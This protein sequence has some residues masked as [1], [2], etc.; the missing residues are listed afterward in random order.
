MEKKNMLEN[1]L[2]EKCTAMMDK[3]ITNIKMYEMTFQ[4]VIEEIYPEHL[5]W[6]VT[7]CD[8]FLHLLGFKDPW[9]TIR[10]IIATV[11]EVV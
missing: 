8:I 5:W 4:D 3:G 1:A 10:E 6:E 9:L 2:I 7:E 11:K